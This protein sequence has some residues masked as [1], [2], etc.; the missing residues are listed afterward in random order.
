MWVILPDKT[1][2][3]ALHAKIVAVDALP[4][5]ARQ[6]LLWNLLNNNA[7]EAI[8]SLNDALK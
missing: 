7:A 2:Y 5:A 8:K 4:D 1:A 3:D 6:K